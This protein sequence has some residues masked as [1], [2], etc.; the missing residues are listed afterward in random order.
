MYITKHS[1]N[2]TNII[3]YEP[4]YLVKILD[5]KKYDNKTCIKIELNHNG[6][7][8]VNNF[9]ENKNIIYSKFEDERMWLK[10]CENS[11]NMIILYNGGHH[12]VEESW[13]WLDY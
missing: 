2:N 5:I 1:T 8:D 11:M 6:S 7:I 4:K 13:E 12:K 9:D 3:K 10:K